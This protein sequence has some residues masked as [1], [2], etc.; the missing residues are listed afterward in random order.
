[1]WASVEFVP[2]F[3]NGLIVSYVPK[4]RSRQGQIYNDAMALLLYLV[5]NV[6][7]YQDARQS[8]SRISEGT[9]IPPTSLKRMIKWHRKNGTE[10]CVLHYVAFKAGITINYEGEPGRIMF[11]Q[12]ATTEEQWA[13]RDTDNGGPLY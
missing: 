10:S 11:A 7:D 12:Y 9:G 6:N 8:Y 5:E 4:W 3:R 2:R 13:R 1:M